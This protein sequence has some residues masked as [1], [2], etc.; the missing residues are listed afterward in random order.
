M[1]ES[2]NARRVVVITGAAS[3]IG[4]AICKRL[5]KP[6][7]CLVVH[8][9]ANRAGLKDVAKAALAAGAEV[10]MVVGD[11]TKD[12][13][14][15]ALV[16]TAV[17]SFGGLDQVVSNAGFPDRT[18]FGK[19]TAPQLLASFDAMAAGFLRL[20]TAALPHLDP[21]PHGRVIAVTSHA[22][23][24]FRLGG[25]RFPATAAAKAGVEALA[26]SLAAQVSPTGTTVNCV[27]PGFIRTDSGLYGDQDGQGRRYAAQIVPLGRLGTADEVAATVAF[28]LSDEAAYI[29]GQSI[30]VNGGLDL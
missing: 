29:T 11:M 30:H 23:H 6:D 1:S 8:T 28:L 15:A 2:R 14:A 21:S 27:V 12:K 9:R 4:A 20:V 5:A 22:A 26:K 18:P 13:T 7:A 19:L 25:L 17:E 10:R 16:A 24:I 3:G